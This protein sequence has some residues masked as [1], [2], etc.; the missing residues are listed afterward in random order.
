MSVQN[1]LNFIHLIETNKELQQKAKQAFAEQGLAGL[2]QLKPHLSFNVQDL[3]LAF[4]QD[5][6]MRR[7]HFSTK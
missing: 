5:W 7:F 3:Q 4:R 1:A 2:C 6:I